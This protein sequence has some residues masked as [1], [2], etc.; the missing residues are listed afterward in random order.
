MGAHHTHM[1]LVAFHLEK[2]H[3][4]ELI[5][6]LFSLGRTCLK[7]FR[8]LKG[9]FKSGFLLHNSTLPWEKNSIPSLKVRATSHFMDD[10]NSR[11]D[12][13]LLL[14]VLSRS[15][16]FSGASRF[17]PVAWQSPYSVTAGSVP[18][19]GPSW[20]SLPCW[21]FPF[22]A[23]CPGPVLSAHSSS[24]GI[25]LRTE[26]GI[27]LET[28]GA[29]LPTDIAQMNEP[30]SGSPL[31]GQGQ[32]DLPGLQ[33]QSIQAKGSSKA[34][35]SLVTSEVSWQGIWAASSQIVMRF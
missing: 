17:C 28:P 3:A 29:Q 18:V 13:F 4:V 26:K 14:E 7:A 9:L 22:L 30:G 35:D 24:G 2:C 27:C 10:T 12:L 21:V 23:P 20:G 16:G 25:G 19:C 34:K 32:E 6:K 31:A 33:R 11:W 8:T 1:Q 5:W 15:L